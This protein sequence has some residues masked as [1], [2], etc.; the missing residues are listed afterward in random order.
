MAQ[1]R[2]YVTVYS[3]EG[4]SLGSVYLP[5]VFSSPIR[6][7]IVDFVHTNMRK[8]KRQPYGVKCHFGPTGI[9]AG[10]QHSAHSWGTGR[11]VS[12]IPRISGSGTNRSG[13][14]AFGKMLIK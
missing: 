5:D 8:N 7:D 4:K 12:R 2:V 9:V 10:H 11:A 13:Q 1:Q 14:G 6:R 3:T